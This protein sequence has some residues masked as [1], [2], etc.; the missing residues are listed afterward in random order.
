MEKYLVGGRCRDVL[1]S[2]IDCT[3]LPEGDLD[4]VV[5]GSSPEEMISLGY[6]QVGNS[7]PVFLHPETKCEYALARKE[8]KDGVGYKGF[9]YQ[10]ENV[11][12]EE[13]LERRDLTINSMA[14][15]P[16]FEIIDPFNGRADIANKTLRHTSDAFADDPVRVLRIARFLAKF[17]PE[18][19]VAPETY[20]LCQKVAWAEFKNLT[21]ER[22]FLEMNK[23]LSEPHPWLFFEFLYMLDYVWFKELFDLK[24]IPQPT[25]HHPENCT[26]DHVML[27]L[28]QGVKF[29]ASPRELYAI[30]CH[31]LGKSPCWKEQGNL[32]GHE[33]TGIP[34]V[35]EIS[36][37]LK[38]PNDYK[39]LAVNVC[40]YHQRSHKAFELRPNKIHNL[41][42]GMGG[43]DN[44]EELYSFSLCNRAD[45]TGRTGLE[46]KEYK[47]D[48]YLL[49][50]AVA[51]NRVDTKKIS[52]ACLAKGQTGKIIGDA[53]RVA[54]IDAIRGVKNKWKI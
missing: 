42:V 6:T 13:D 16:D 40:K 10:W 21:A 8:Q 19:T 27:C 53:I 25:T 2:R 24:G 39:T 12:L 54:Q 14:W 35:E 1:I 17:G 23:A 29:N 4:Y 5:V 34:Y 22:V 31:D 15:G 43:I 20:A 18:W 48:S 28:K 46:E 41:L 32:H 11:T 36:R 49:G 47:Q 38:V 26:F 30:L 45:A 52:S 44:A 50:C 51:C 37:R 33:D 7:F 9:S 3:Q